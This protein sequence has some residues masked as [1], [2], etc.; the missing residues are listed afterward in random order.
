[1]KIVGLR[2]P[3][4]LEY[5][6]H[7]PN[8]TI[9]PNPAI[10]DTDPAPTLAAPAPGTKVASVAKADK[11]NLALAAAQSKVPQGGLDWD[12]RATTI[13]A[14]A[15]GPLLDPREM[16][17]HNIGEVLARIKKAPY[18]EDL[19][20]LF[21]AH[22]FDQ[23]DLALNEALFALVRFQLEDP[24]FHPYSSKYDAYLAGKAKL[25]EAEMRGLKLF[26]DP[27][28]GNCSSCH[29]DKPSRDGLFRPAFTDYQFEALGAPR[30]HDIPANRDPHYY[31][32]GLCGP[33][34]TDYAHAASYCGLFKTPTLRNVATRKAFFHNGVFHSLKDVLHFYVE[35]ETDPAKWYPKLPN[36]EIDLYDDLPPEYKRNIDVVDAPF[37]R[38]QGEKPALNDAEIDDLIAFLNTLTDGYRLDQSGTRRT[39][40]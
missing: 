8:F 30:N 18:A 17:N 22:I 27:K 4:S 9:G 7:T 37:D 24:S 40:K 39:E 32:L 33:L 35:R 26:E 31:D 1:M 25:T 29:I 19:K 10:P 3:R 38:K 36:G 34:R 13:Q 6:E 12:G 2:A 28:K 11:N 16:A 5:L 23:P 20:K 21:G 15:V 14:Q